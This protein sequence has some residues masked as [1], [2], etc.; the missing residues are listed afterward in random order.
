M[1]VISSL[2]AC[3]RRPA[4]LAVASAI[5]MGER[6][7]HGREAGAAYRTCT[8]LSA[9]SEIIL[10]VSGPVRVTV[11]LQLVASSLPRTSH[12]DAGV[13]T[14]APP[15]TEITCSDS[16]DRHKYLPMLSRTLG[17]IPESALLA[18]STL[19]LAKP[20]PHHRAAVSIAASALPSLAPLALAMIAA[21]T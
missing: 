15:R 5:A 2:V 8:T 20:S 11:Y 9:G 21:T 10:V 13:S 19:A 3:S 7:A 1:N 14:T 6:P 4:A 16:P 12:A 17:V 18:G